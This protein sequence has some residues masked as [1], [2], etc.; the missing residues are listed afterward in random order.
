MSNICVNF[1]PWIAAMEPDGDRFLDL[2]EQCKYIATENHPR[3]NDEFQGYDCSLSRDIWCTTSRRNKMVLAKP[4]KDSEHFILSYRKCKSLA[5]AENC[6]VRIIPLRYHFFHDWCRI[7]FARESQQWSQTTIV[8]WTLWSKDIATENQPHY[9][10]V[11]EKDMTALYTEISD[12]PRAVKNKMKLAR[13]WKDSEHFVLSNTNDRKYKS[14]ASAENC[15]IRVIDLR[16][17]FFH[18]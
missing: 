4:W 16:Y 1:R 3:Y 18:N 17:H 9:N 11:L 8:S 10:D 5:S 6:K 12:A 13:L 7:F 2:M 15:K 14:L